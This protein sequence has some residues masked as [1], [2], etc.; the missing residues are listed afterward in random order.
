ML[1][2]YQVE[3]KRKIKS[4][5]VCE[6]EI[7]HLGDS[8]PFESDFVRRKREENLHQREHLM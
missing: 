4:N 5:C 8:A 2:T 7:F 6:Q 3:I 1:W